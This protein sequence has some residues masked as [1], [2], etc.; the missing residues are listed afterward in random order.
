[1]PTPVSVGGGSGLIIGSGA[2]GGVRRRGLGGSLHDILED[3]ARGDGGPRGQRIAQAGAAPAALPATLFG[4]GLHLP[5]RGLLRGFLMRPPR[6]PLRLAG[7]LDRLLVLLGVEELPGAVQRGLGG[8]GVRADPHREE[9]PGLVDRPGRL[10][11]L[12]LRL[13]G[14][15]DIL[16]GQPLGL[17]E[18]L[19]AAAE[20]LE[21]AGP[22]AVR[23][24]Q[25]DP[26]LLEHLGRGPEPPVRGL[27]VL[28]AARKQVGHALAARPEPGRIRRATADGSGHR[29]SPGPARP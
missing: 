15:A 3:D 9:R 17:L 25:V 8:R 24:G 20:L 26:D 2:E 23:L 18:V 10:V 5:P 21:P 13:A 14:Q 7:A 27:P 4:V 1:M 16:A 11:D 29:P 22:V 28:S 6:R 19:A 12:R